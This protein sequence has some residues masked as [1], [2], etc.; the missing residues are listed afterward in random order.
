MVFL[1]KKDFILFFFF[2]IC[3]TEMLPPHLNL[4][5]QQPDAKMEAVN[6]KGFNGTWRDAASQEPLA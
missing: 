3:E 2:V 5:G 6:K 1:E 4:L